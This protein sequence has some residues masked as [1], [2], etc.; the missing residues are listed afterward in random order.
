MEQASWARMMAGQRAA[1][2]R[3][4]DVEP[5]RSAEEALAAGL[6][7]WSLRPD[8]F[9]APKDSVRLREEALAREAWR[10]LHMR[11]GADREPR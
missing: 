8:L 10:R 11:L 3:G 6:G 7:L 2:D 5:P 1:A 9:D 4:R